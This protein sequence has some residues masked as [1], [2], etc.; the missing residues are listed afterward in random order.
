VPDT[1]F[2]PQTADRAFDQAKFTMLVVV[3]D[4]AERHFERAAFRPARTLEIIRNQ[5]ILHIAVLCVGE[6][7]ETY[8]A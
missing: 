1:V 5:N 3:Y 7:L 6:R 2:V 4:G 8:G